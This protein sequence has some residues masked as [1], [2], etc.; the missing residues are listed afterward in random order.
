MKRWSTSMLTKEVQIQTT[1]CY[2]LTQFRLLKM[3]VQ[4]YQELASMW[5]K[6]R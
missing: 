1:M 5:S 3:Q 4:Q 6:N 2:N